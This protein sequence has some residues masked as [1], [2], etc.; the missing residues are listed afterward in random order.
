MI[1]E[2]DNCYQGMLIIGLTL[3]SIR[4]QENDRLR[5]QYS[6]VPQQNNIRDVQQP[7]EG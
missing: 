5:G 7:Q 4:Q 6:R 1:L 2:I 3:Y